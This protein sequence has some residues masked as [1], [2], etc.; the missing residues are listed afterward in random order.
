[1]KVLRIPKKNGTYREVCVP[2]LPL[3]RRLRSML[4]RLAALV[5][6]AD[7]WDVIHG[8]MP[9]RSPVTNAKQ[10]VG[11]EHTVSMDLKD[12]FDRVD[13]HKTRIQHYKRYLKLIPKGAFVLVNGCKRY[14]KQG[15]PTAPPI[16]N[17]FA[18]SLDN[19]LCKRFSVLGIRYTR[20]AD[21]LTFSFNDPQL[22]NTVIESVTGICHIFGL[23]VNE[24]KTK[25]MHSHQGRRIITGIA[26]DDDVHPTREMKRRLRAAKHQGRTMQAM[27]LEEWCRLKEPDLLNYVQKKQKGLLE[28]MHYLPYELVVEQQIALH[29]LS[30]TN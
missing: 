18:V 29:V 26:V 19:E 11:F 15:L 8:F 12:F 30:V 3:K 17:L 22:C 2:C 1:M 24:N 4:P 5:K 25:V 7:K 21:D 9:G 6:S 10:H 28:D 23:P 16:A 27:G 13:D 14:T 20:Y